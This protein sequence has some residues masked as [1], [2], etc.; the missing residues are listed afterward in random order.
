MT[1]QELED[2]LDLHESPKEIGGIVCYVRSEDVRLLFSKIKEHEWISVNTALPEPRVDCLTFTNWGLIAVRR[3]NTHK[4]PEVHGNKVTH[5]MPI[6]IP[7]QLIAL[8]Q[9]IT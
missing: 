1:M 2:W 9:E 4:F 3:R 5:W 7:K 6:K 8:A